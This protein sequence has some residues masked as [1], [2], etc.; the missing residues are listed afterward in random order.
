[1]ASKSLRELKKLQRHQFNKVTKEELI[2]AILTGG[3][4]GTTL[5]ARQ[6]E[7]LDRIMEELTDMRRMM[8]AAQEESKARIT[9]LENTVKKQSEIIM[10]H[11]LFLEQLDRQKRETNLVLFGM[12]D[13]QLALDGA[14][15]EDA[16][17]IK[18]W[19]AV[20]ADAV[21]RSHRI[22]WVNL[23]KAAAG[24]AHF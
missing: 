22:D 1:M 10:Q 3:D 9:E 13:D 8:V 18:V 12:P 20:Q 2:D 21:V 24:H 23:H 4:D 7:K 11:Q 14:T 6:D 19:S 16:R 5:A 15:T 17:I